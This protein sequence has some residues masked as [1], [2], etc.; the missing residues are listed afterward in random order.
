MGPTLIMAG[1]P[2]FCL[3][4]LRHVLEAAVCKE[5]YVVQREAKMTWDRGQWTRRCS[6]VQHVCQLLPPQQQPTSRCSLS[7][8]EDAK[9]NNRSALGKDYFLGGLCFFFYSRIG[10]M[11]IRITKKVVR[12]LLIIN[13]LR[14][15]GVH[16]VLIDRGWSRASEANRSILWSCRGIRAITVRREPWGQALWTITIYHIR[17]TKSL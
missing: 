3:T 16:P 12:E 13:G 1:T 7:S 6:P 5:E 17:S 8:G 14:M 9:A 11:R 4:L 2:V 10:V 15:Y